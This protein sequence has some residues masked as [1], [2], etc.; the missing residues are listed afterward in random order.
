MT[1]S[2]NKQ[3][4]KDINF[5]LFDFICKNIECILL[6]R[7]L[8]EINNTVMLKFLSQIRYRKE[9]NVYGLVAREEQSTKVLLE[10]SLAGQGCLKFVSVS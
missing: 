1:R 6:E 4:V 2:C 8:V 7:R 10:V 9:E 3:G 5:N